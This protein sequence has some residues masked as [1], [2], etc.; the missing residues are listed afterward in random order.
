MLCQLDETTLRCPRCG[1][2]AKSLPHYRNCQ[3][4]EEMARHYVSAMAR[5]RIKIPPLRL[6][7]AIAAG[8]TMVGVTEDRV[9][10]IVGGDC[11]CA[12][13]KSKLDAVGEGVSKT[14]ERAANA[15][16]E[17]VL[18]YGVT[19]DDVAAV[20]QSIAASPLTNQGLKDKAAGR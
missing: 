12:A 20:A 6:G 16:L 3:T 8:L 17:A 13:R 4:I 2:L 9:K 14:I 11:G 5:S 10:K 18:P 7:S 19:E 1:F 15:A